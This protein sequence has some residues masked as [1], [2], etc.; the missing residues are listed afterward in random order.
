[1]EENIKKYSDY[2]YY[3]S[4]I[5]NTY[6]I[7]GDYKYKNKISQTYELTFHYSLLY[8]HKKNKINFITIS[9]NNVNNIKDFN[10]EFIH[11]TLL[12]RCKREE[13]YNFLKNKNMYAIYYLDD[14]LLIKPDHLCK[15]KI[16]SNFTNKIINIRKKLLLYSNIIYVSTNYLKLELEKILNKKNIYSNNIVCSYNTN[17]I[18]NIQKKKKDKFIIGYMGSKSHIEDLN[19]ITNDIIRILLKYE[20]VYFEVAGSI[21]L[22]KLFNNKNIKNKV[23]HHGSF[24]PY[25]KWLNK[26]NSFGWDLGLAPCKINTFNKCKSP[27]KFIEYTLCNIPVVAS[28]INFY[29]NIIITNYNGFL[30]EDYNWFLLIEN[31]INNKLILKDIL[32]KSK[33]YCLNNFSLKKNTHNITN[34]LYK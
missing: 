1:M 12:I 28:N 20:N 26:L 22:S 21:K 3:K 6:L 11:K 16:L 27:I 31:I 17:L 9:E 8:L 30:I 33:Q 34:I 25:M 23:K 32:M 13:T 15:E 5:K 19:M 7:I 18:K 10:T 14:N 29:E 4:N 24:S 2:Y